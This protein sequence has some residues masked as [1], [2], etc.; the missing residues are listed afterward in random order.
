LYAVESLILSLADRKKFEYLSILDTIW[1]W[2]HSWLRHV[3]RHDGLLKNILEGK[4]I[5]KQA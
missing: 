5:G 1:C 3:L 4:I 2:K